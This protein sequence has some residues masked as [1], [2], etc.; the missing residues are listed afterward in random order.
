MTDGKYIYTIWRLKNLLRFTQ[1]VYMY[2]NN[3][4]IINNTCYISMF[5]CI[6]VNN[7]QFKKMSF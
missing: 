3:N 6:L 7:S 4:D 5:K 1:R 2:I